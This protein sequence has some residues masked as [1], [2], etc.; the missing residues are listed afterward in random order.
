MHTIIWPKG[1]GN[2]SLFSKVF[3][4]ENYIEVL[5]DSWGVFVLLLLLADSKLV[6]KLYQ[7]PKIRRQMS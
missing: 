5:G 7:S 1:T 6:F 2:G 4:P 3:C